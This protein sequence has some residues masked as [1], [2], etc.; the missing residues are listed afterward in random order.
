MRR[1]V[2]NRSTTAY[3]RLDSK[4]CKACWKCIEACPE[5]VFGKINIFVH[6]HAKISNPARCTGCR[7]C[8]KACEYG[9]IKPVTEREK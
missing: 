4:E 5:G 1:R 6:K 7:K 2:H 9:A 8:V 3:V